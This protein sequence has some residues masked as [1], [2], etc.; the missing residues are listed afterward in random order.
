MRLRAIAATIITTIA[1]VGLGVLVP[2][3]ASADAPVVVSPANGGSLPSGSTGPLVI[4][5]PAT[6]GTYWVSVE[7]GSFDYYWSTGGSKPYA[8]RQVI[9]IDPLEGFGGEDLGGSTCQ[10]EM[11]GGSPFATTVAAFTV[12]SPRLALGDVSASASAFYPTV[13]DG[14]LDETELAFTVNR[15]AETM[16]TVTDPNGKTFYTRSI[17]VD[18]A[19]EYH[20][21]W[22]GQTTSGRPIEPGRY[23]ATITAVA[24][25]VT[26]SQSARVQVATKKV[27]RRQ[28]LRKD[29]WGS[30]EDT[31]GNCRTDWDDE[32]VLLDCWGGAYARS[33]YTF[34]IPGNATNIRWGARTSYTGLDNGRG[35]LTKNG[36]RTSRTMFQIRVQ[37]T[38][39]RAVQV[40]GASVSYKARVKI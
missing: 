35:A 34:K 33:T 11:S 16:L 9:P 13:K 40:H 30:R 12:S 17:W 7:C 31:G 36:T 5:F 39:W 3:P 4:D 1:T 28:T 10:V 24:D 14:Y 19:G 2:A 26:L 27:F 21:P 32:A 18:R 8:G 6:G 15:R 22:K 29:H 38:G 37:V 20:V 25:G 23:R